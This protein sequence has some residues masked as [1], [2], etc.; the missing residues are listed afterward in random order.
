MITDEG[1]ELRRA[2]GSRTNIV[3]WNQNLK[4]AVDS[5]LN[6]RQVIWDKRSF[7]IPV[8][9]ENRYLFVNETG[10]KLIKS[11]MDTA[12]NRL[13]RLAIDAGVIEESQRFG[14][15]DLKRRGT[16]DTIGTRAEKQEMT[17]H[18]SAAM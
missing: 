18:K 7:P 1:I 14:M 16:T 9:S 5:L 12:F 13:I 3:L 4:T 10:G 2:K 8:K 15:H 6:R 17:G 11:S